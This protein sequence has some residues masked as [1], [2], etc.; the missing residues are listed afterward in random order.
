MIKKLTL[1]II[2]ISFTGCETV[3]EKAGGLKKIG[4]TCPPKEE[5]TLKDI[6]CKEPK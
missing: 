2:L 4:D 6:L 3:K 1:M 5:R